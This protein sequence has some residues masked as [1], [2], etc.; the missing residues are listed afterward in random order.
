MT[1]GIIVVVGIILMVTIHE[2]GHF[3]AAK[4]T[5]MKATEFFFGF[6]PRQAEAYEEDLVARCQAIADGT[7]PSQSCRRVI[8]P[9]LPEDLRVTRSGQHFIVFVETADAI[10]IVDFLHGRSDLP[11]RLAR[12][13]GR[14]V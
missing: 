4:A 9:N 1:A 10:V 2:A 6:G 3:L 8:D 12:L 7:A 11:A 5:G 13:S 14:D